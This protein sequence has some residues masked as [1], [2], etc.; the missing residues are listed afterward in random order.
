VVATDYFLEEGNVGK[1]HLDGADKVRVLKLESNTL[2]LETRFALNFSTVFVGIHA[3][4]HGIAVKKVGCGK[5]LLATWQIS[6]ISIA[7]RIHLTNAYAPKPSKR[8]S[9]RSRHSRR[10]DVRIKP[11]G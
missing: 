8:A 11:I 1:V 10:A 9:G 5:I 2:T 7:A 3:R 6:F 4:P